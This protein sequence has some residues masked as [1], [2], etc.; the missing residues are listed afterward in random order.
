MVVPVDVVQHDLH[1]GFEVL[2]VQILA[3]RVVASW[4]LHRYIAVV[5]VVVVGVVAIG[6]EVCVGSQWTTDGR[7][8]LRL[9]LL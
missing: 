5:V 9:G 8:L 3:S 7:I 1:V 6:P 4:R 2:L